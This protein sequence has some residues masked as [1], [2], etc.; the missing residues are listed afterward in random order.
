MEQAS[1]RVEEKM[2]ETIAGAGSDKAADADGRAYQQQP[3]AGRDGDETGGAD[4]RGQGATTLRAAFRWSRSRYA[5]WT[6][7]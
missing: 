2:W 6:G 7:A 3:L 4:A 1:E 5:S